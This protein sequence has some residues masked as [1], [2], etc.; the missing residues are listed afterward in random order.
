M[1]TL[2]SILIVF[3]AIVCF[4]LIGIVLLQKSTGDGNG[5]SFGSGAES[6]FGA[7]AGN[8]LTRGTVVLAVLFL[9][10]TLLLCILRPEAR[11]QSLGEEI[12]T[13]QAAR[14][15]AEAAATGDSDDVAD[16]LGDIAPTGGAAEATAGKAT[17]AVGK[18][19]EAV[20]EKAEEAVG[21]AEE[22]AKAVEK[23]AEDAAKAAE[24]TAEKAAEAVQKAAEAIEEKAAEAAKA[25]EEKADEAVKAV[26]AAPE[27]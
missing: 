9:L 25:V 24:A 4:L 1:S 3:E 10:N 7:Q 6:V 22:A 15:K 20:E 14:Q 23:K 5:L 18:A 12:A 16:L 26:E 13:E 21:K 17:E 8:V 11:A 2:Y 19:T 27:A